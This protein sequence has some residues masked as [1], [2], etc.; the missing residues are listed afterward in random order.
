M[1]NRYQQQQIIGIPYFRRSSQEAQRRQWA[2]ISRQQAQMEEWANWNRVQLLAPCIDDATGTNFD[3]PGFKELIRVARSQKNVAT[4]ILCTEVDR[5]G[6][7]TE[8][9]ISYWKY[10]KNKLG[11]E[12]N[13]IN[14]WY[15]FSN[16][17]TW[18]MFCHD[19]GSAQAESMKISKRTKDTKDSVRRSGFYADKPPIAWTFG[20]PTPRGRK[21]LIA[22]EPAFSVCK[23]FLEMMYHTDYTQAEC[24]AVVSTK[25]YV[26]P[27]STASRLCRSPLVYGGNP[28]YRYQGK[29]RVLVDVVYPAQIE[30]MI[31]KHMFD[32]IQR[33]LRYKEPQTVGKT[34]QRFN[35][36]FPL[37]TILRCPECAKKTTA[38]NSTGKSGKKFPYNECKP[39][40]WRLNDR[41]AQDILI[42]YLAQFE[43]DPSKAELVR[44]AA[45]QAVKMVQGNKSKAKGDANAELEKIR[46][47][48][49]KLKQSFAD[50]DIS[51]FNEQMDYYKQQE[52]KAK[53]KLS[54]AEEAINLTLKARNEL[55]A[56]LSGGLGE[57][58]S[59]KATPVQKNRFLKMVFPQGFTFE[60]SEVRTP[61]INE[62]MRILF[63]LSGGYDNKKGTTQPFGPD[64]PGCGGE[65]DDWR[66]QDALLVESFFAS[67]K[68][69]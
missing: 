60:N 62:Q 19:I 54:E 34:L 43:I 9:Y 18:A 33:K 45:A 29:K 14:R 48:K 24:R 49:A 28:I 51:V 50:M 37:K 66:T 56:F 46:Q 12:V 38:S 41:K 55:V 58:F 5:F 2:S 6:R 7:E 67:L 36:D 39:C 47:G 15:D 52:L 61:R 42:T 59:Q 35:P 20:A 53:S 27:R 68:A 16:P 25:E 69:A 57:W 30:P 10:F 63:L 22:N 31:T 8:E 3:R 11:I 4:H 26:L 32:A 44:K 64:N 17:D 65:R 13:F 1:Y 40:G 21:P 23:A